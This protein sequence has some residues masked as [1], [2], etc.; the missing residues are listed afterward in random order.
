VYYTYT[1]MW[2][3]TREREREFIR[4]RNLNHGGRRGGEPEVGICMYDIYELHS[5][6]VSKL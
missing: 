2:Y 6:I 1:Y 5:N 4:N 3:G